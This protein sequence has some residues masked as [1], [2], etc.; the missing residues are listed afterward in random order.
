MAITIVNRSFSHAETSA[1]PFT[2]AT[3]TAG[4][5]LVIAISTTSQGGLFSSIVT[6]AGDAV[7]GLPFNSQLNNSFETSGFELVTGVF[8]IPVGIGG[9]TTMTITTSGSFDAWVYELS[10]DSPPIAIDAATFMATTLNAPGAGYAPGDTGFIDGPI[11]DATYEIDTV[12][13]SGE[14]VTYHVTANGS[15]YQTATNVVT[16]IN[17][18]GGDGN[19]TV[20]ITLA[21]GVNNSAIGTPGTVVTGPTQVGTGL[22][23]FYVACMTVGEV[24]NVAAPWTLDTTDIGEGTSFGFGAAYLLG[25]GTQAAIFNQTFNGRWSVSAAAFTDAGAPAT[26]GNII[27]EKVTA[28][29]GSAQSFDFTTDYG[30]PFS[31]LDG[32]SNDSGQI[33]AG[34]YAV[35]EAPVAGWAT[36]TSQDPSAIVLGAGET[37]TVTFTNTQLGH[38]IIAKVTNP[39]G[40]TQSF[41]FTSDYGAPF[42]LLD[43]ES[44]DSGPIA[45]GTYSVV[46]APVTGWDTTTDSDPTNIV[47]AAG[48][49]VTVTFTNTETHI[50]V[51][52]VTDP[53]GSSQ[54]FD[55]VTNYGSNAFS[56]TDGTSNDSGPLAEGTY[57]VSETP[58]SGWN[59]SVTTNPLGLD[60]TALTLAAGDTVVVTFT[61]TQVVPP[62]AVPC[63]KALTR[64]DTWELDNGDPTWAANDSVPIAWYDSNLEQQKVGITRPIA[65]GTIGLLYVQLA[66]TLTGAG[67]AMT[68]PDDWTPYVLWGALTD[69][70]SHDG[71]AY[72]PLRAK[73][74]EQRYQEGVELARLVLKGV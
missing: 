37:I 7:S 55:Y 63:G 62:P 14:V 11:G 2:I 52:K 73:Y 47:L 59:T 4:N 41:D 1:T 70:F 66:A 64:V 35:V 8:W 33:E 23:D 20:D 19:F 49:T 18:G 9:A 46:E 40:A 12:G 36:T 25:S 39:T 57:S 45:P 27:I 58:V 43:G 38:V 34:T 17:T 24:I 67:V 5:T 31:L 74:C 30:A 72:D 65:N 26:T 15:G 44:N 69:L 16:L 60:P 22:Q 13:G 50:I 53:L 68:I 29:T 6:D 56:L 42:S 3:T 28:P 51:Q 61:N 71:P 10:S 32:E 54:S 48:D 21:C